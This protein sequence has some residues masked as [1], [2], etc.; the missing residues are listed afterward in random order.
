MSRDFL[1]I[2]LNW[3]APNE[4]A[5]APGLRAWSAG[6]PKKVADTPAY[7]YAW[8]V[9]T[10]EILD[11][12]PKLSDKELRQVYHVLDAVFRER[13]QIVMEDEYGTVTEEDIAALAGEAWSISSKR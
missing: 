9:S 1:A 13:H 12:L 4:R 8:S 11:S 5:R 6:H 10:A 7:R 2:V 3:L